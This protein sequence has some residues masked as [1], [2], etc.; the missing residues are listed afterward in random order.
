MRRLDHIQTTIDRKAYLKEKKFLYNI[1]KDWYAFL[2][3]RMSELPK[4]QIVELGSGGGFI[5][6][7]HP[8]VI[9]S[10]VMDLPHVDLVFSAENMPFESASI[11]AFF[12]IDVLHHI[13]DC[14]NFFREVDRCLKKGGMLI[15]SEPANTPW[16]KFVYQHFHHETFD[17]HAGWEIKDASG[18][19]SSANGAIPWI[20]FKRDRKIFE[21]RFPNLDIQNIELH[22]PFRYLI[23]GGF[24][25]KSLLPASLYKAVYFCENIL[26]PIYPLIAMF[27]L[28]EIRKR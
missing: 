27:Q 16:S 24:S 4:G 12:M 3:R 9:T 11:S 2:T 7:I 25:K 26:K 1:Y 13:P 20:V 17:P 22:T 23:S 18:P 5:K 6:D 28:I 21:Q 8:E 10:D 14:N 15:M 19:L